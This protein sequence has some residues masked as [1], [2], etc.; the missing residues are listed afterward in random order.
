LWATFKELFTDTAGPIF[1]DIQAGEPPEY[2]F[3]NRRGA[4]L[5]WQPSIERPILRRIEAPQKSARRPPG[6]AKSRY[7]DY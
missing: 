1:K 2:A 7:G 5:G 3:C 6:H 4:L